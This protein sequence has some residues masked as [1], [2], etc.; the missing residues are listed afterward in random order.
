[1]DQEYRRH[2]MS[3]ARSVPNI[4][5]FEG[6]Y[7]VVVCGLDRIID[8]KSEYKLH[9]TMTGIR[10]QRQEEVESKSFVS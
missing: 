2:E 4:P 1:M 8:G 7:L 6:A 5:P 10:C 9:V 3:V